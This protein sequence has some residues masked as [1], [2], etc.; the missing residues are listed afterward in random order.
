M[1]KRKPLPEL[2]PKVL[3]HAFDEAEARLKDQNALTWKRFD[4]MSNIDNCNGVL[5][6]F[7]ETMFLLGVIYGRKQR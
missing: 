6:D 5:C 7:G 4:A 1:S 2:S 3:G